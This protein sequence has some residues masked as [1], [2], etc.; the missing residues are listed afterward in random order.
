MVGKLVGS[1]TLQR[2]PLEESSRWVMF[3]S[4]SGDLIFSPGFVANLLCS[5]LGSPQNFSHVSSLS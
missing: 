3:R 2:S 1:E 5:D 4:C